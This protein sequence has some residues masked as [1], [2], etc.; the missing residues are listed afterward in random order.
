MLLEEKDYWIAR[1]RALTS[2][3]EKLRA[4]LGS[5]LQEEEE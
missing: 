2:E 5:E 4:L 3:K 1:S